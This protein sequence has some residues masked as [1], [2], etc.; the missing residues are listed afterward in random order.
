MH[1]VGNE[2]FNVQ[3]MASSIILLGMDKTLAQ[4]PP[5]SRV[6]DGSRPIYRQ[7]DHLRVGSRHLG[8]RR[9]ED[10]EKVF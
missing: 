8:C 3:I 1:F 10:L 7:T 4:G 2:S 6:Q 5:P 9:R